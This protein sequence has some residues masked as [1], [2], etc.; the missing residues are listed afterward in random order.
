MKKLTKAQK[1][2]IWIGMICFTF[3]AIFMCVVSGGIGA[4]ILG[5]TFLFS[6]K[7][8][9]AMGLMNSNGNWIV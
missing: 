3:L 2:H 6:R 8:K 1:I 5:I 4:V 7:L 9:T